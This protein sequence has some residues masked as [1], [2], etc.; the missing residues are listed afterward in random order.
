M[1]RFLRKPLDKY[2]KVWYNIDT[3]NIKGR[4]RMMKIMAILQLRFKKF[5]IYMRNLQNLNLIV[6]YLIDN[7]LYNKEVFGIILLIPS[8]FDI[9]HP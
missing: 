5:R 4:D 1:R 2:I 3:K 7:L 6:I 9:I 8:I